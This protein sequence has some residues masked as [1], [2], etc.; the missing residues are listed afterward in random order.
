LLIKTST[1][2]FLQPVLK[3]EVLIRRREPEYSHGELLLENKFKNPNAA[4]GNNQ[5]EKD[6]SR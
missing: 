5:K 3:P 1:V 6:F 4:P 2:N